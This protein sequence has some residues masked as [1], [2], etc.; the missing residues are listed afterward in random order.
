MSALRASRAWQ[1]ILF[2]HDPNGMFRG[3][4]EW[5][6]LF[7]LSS[8]KLKKVVCLSTVT[9]N[10]KQ[11]YIDTGGGLGMVYFVLGVWRV[12]PRLLSADS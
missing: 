5:I 12:P 1:R 3:I 2:K 8:F 9:R 4:N 7:K 10:C 6:E 11:K